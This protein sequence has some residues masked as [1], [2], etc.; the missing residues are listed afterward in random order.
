MNTKRRFLLFAA[1]L[2]TL[3]G[4][5]LIYI[6]LNDLQSTKK[7]ERKALYEAKQMIEVEKKTPQQ[8][9]KKTGISVKPSERQQGDVVGILEIPRLKAEL[10]IIEGTDEDDLAKGV[11]HYKDTA[12]PEGKDQILL[13]GHR[14]TVFR[15]LGELKKGDILRIRMPYGDFDY[16]I[17]D[18][19][20]VEAD[21]RSIIKPTAPDEILTLSTC[22][23]FSFVGDAPQRYILTA[24]RKKAS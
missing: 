19:E 18:S 2:L 24:F 23:P 20:I 3:T 10:P 4:A 5:A 1:L 14:D 21:D 12:L 16:S 7:N 13:S 8:A 11:G 6:S 9:D 22:Y 17:S 15:R